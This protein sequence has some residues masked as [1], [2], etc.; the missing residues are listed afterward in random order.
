MEAFSA[1]RARIYKSACFA[2]SDDGLQAVK[3]ARIVSLSS[4]SPLS[5][6]HKVMKQARFNKLLTNQQFRIPIANEM[7]SAAILFI[8]LSVIL[9]VE[10]LLVLR[11]NLLA[12]PVGLKLQLHHFQSHSILTVKLRW[13]LLKVRTLYLLQFLLLLGNHALFFLEEH[14]IPHLLPAATLLRRGQCSCPLW[15]Y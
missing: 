11:L 9:A 13:H 1:K 12:S 15:F 7:G 5:K 6:S 3:D 14:G 4:V 8:T 2:S 10:L